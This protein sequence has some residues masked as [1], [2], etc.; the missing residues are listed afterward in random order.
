MDSLASKHFVTFLKLY[1]EE[2]GTENG[3]ESFVINYSK[4]KTTKQQY[5]L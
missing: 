5:Y 1:K 3:Q 4:I 2:I